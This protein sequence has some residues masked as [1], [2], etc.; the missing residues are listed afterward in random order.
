MAWHVKQQSYECQML[1]ACCGLYVVVS[2]SD[3]LRNGARMEGQRAQG[4]NKRVILVVSRWAR[5]IFGAPFLVSLQLSPGSTA[6]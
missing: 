1:F 3:E 2:L 6:L 5:Q 4:D